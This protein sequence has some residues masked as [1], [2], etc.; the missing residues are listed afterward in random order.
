MGAPII[1]TGSIAL[2]MALGY[3]LFGC[4]WIVG[5]DQLV[6]LLFSDPASLTLVQSWKGLCFVLLSAALIFALG[7]FFLRALAASERRYHALFADSPEALVIYDLDDLRIIDANAAAGELLGYAAEDMVGLAITAFMPLAVAAAVPAI[8]PRLREPGPFTSVWRLRHHD[9]R[10]LDVSIHA[11]AYWEK[12]HHCRQALLIDVTAR[13]RAETELLRTLD[14]LAGANERMREVSY[15]ISHDL[16]EPLRQVSGFVQLLE[17]RYAEHLDAEATQFIGY[18]VEG[19]GRLKALIADVEDFAQQRDV[20]QV[21]AVAANTVMA[22]VL[23][24]LRRP[25]GVAAAHVVVATLPDVVVDP[26]RLAV[27]F[28]ALVDNAVKFRRPDIAC[29]IVVNATW[30]GECWVFRVQ[31][32]GLGIDSEFRATVFSL[33]RRLHTRDRIPGNGTGLALAKKMVE[34]WGG[35]IWVEP[36]PGGGSIFAFTL[37]GA[38]D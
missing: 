9:G 35:R 33:F 20:S 15:A 13:I 25:I 37:R 34:S 38:G 12:G 17:R 32:N 5:S 36:A 24:D 23:D 29:E 18:A 14:E 8:L 11:Q 19:V 22:A 16:Q 10:E 27:V 31:D 21:Q 6:A 1:S 30:G 4:V 2:R 7:A 3:A 26:R 28:H